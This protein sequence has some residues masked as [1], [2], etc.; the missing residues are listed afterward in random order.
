MKHQLVDLFRWQNHNLQKQS[1]LLGSCFFVHLL[2]MLDFKLMMK[3][4][5]STLNS[6]INVLEENLSNLINE[7]AG[8]NVILVILTNLVNVEFN[9]LTH[10]WFRPCTANTYTHST[11]F[12]QSKDCNASRITAIDRALSLTVIY[13]SWTTA[14][15][16]L[17]STVIAK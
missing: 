1:G 3:W 9:G 7:L 16:Q 14:N 8:T 15:V 13:Y 12:V 10:N 2:Y 6:R 4:N 11:A 17:I 5:V